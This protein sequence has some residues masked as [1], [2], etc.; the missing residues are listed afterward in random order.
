MIELARLRNRAATAARERSAAALRDALRAARTGATWLWARRPPAS[1]AA[2]IAFA[3]LMAA[4]SAWTILAQAGLPRALPAR[5]DW[6]AARA[7][8]DRDGLPGDAVALSPAWA[9]RAREVLPASLPVFAEPRYAG[10]DLVGIRRVWL[11]SLPD[12]PRFGWAAEVDLLERASGSEAPVRLGALAVTRYDLAFPTLPLAF[13]PDRLA[14]ASVTLG[15]E[16]CPPDGAGRF[17]CGDAAVIERSVREVAGVA[18]PCL[19]ATAPARLDFPLVI[20]LPPIRLGGTLHGHAGTPGGAG[21][22]APV[23]VAVQLDGEE[24]GAAEVVPQAW[25]SFRIDTTR[26][27]GQTRPL[28]LVV[29]SPAPLALCLDAVVLP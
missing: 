20:A 21:A 25:A 17:R 14:R 16:P 15:G 3:V 6:N 9:E 12:A 13:L 23:R 22:A 7:L 19:V 26:V 29:T 11:L 1:R 5:L 10:E 28:A 24:L 8:L 27:A 2:A 4:V 18:R